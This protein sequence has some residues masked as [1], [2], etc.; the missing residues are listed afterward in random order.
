MSPDPDELPIVSPCDEK[1]IPSLCE[2]STDQSVIGL[3]CKVKNT[4]PAVELQIWRFPAGDGNK[5]VQ[6]KDAVIVTEQ[7]TVPLL[8]NLTENGKYNVIAERSISDD[9]D[10]VLS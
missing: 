5:I 1:P 2:I 9:D 6:L 3:T 4:F 10:V 7:V 8:G